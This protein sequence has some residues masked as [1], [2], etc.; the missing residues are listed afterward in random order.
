MRTIKLIW[1]MERRE[2]VRYMTLLLLAISPIRAYR[3]FGYTYGVIMHSIMAAIIAAA[4]ILIIAQAAAKIHRFRQAKRAAE[5]MGPEHPDYRA[6]IMNT[7]WEDEAGYF[8]IPD[9]DKPRKRIYL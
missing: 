8:V 1:E 4:V 6:A 2:I 3:Y 7:I 5:A 9:P